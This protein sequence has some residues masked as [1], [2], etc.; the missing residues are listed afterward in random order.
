MLLV[1]LMVADTSAPPSC[2]CI[3]EGKLTCHSEN[4]ISYNFHYSPHLPKYVTARCSD[5]YPDFLTNQAKAY[6]PG[7][8]NYVRI[9]ND[10][11]VVKIALQKY[12]LQN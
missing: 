4:L 7:L 10:V 11:I 2:N 3:E 6:S 5:N 1:V 12:Y 8:L 9:M